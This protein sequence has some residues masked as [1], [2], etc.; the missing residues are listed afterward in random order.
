MGVGVGGDRE[1]GQGV[2]Q[3]L[4]KEGGRLYRRIFIKWGGLAPLCQLCKLTSKIPHPPVTTIFEKS[5]Y[6][7][8]GGGGGG[9][10]NVMKMIGKVFEPR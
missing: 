8:R 5:L 3:D 9:G 10:S 4:K 1:V 2:G 6:E 7:G